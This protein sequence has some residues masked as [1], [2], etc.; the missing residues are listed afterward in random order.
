MKILLIILIYII[1]VFG[2]WLW[3]YFQFSY[4]KIHTFGDILD[5]TNGFAYIPFINTIAGV[6]LVCIFGMIYVLSYTIEHIIAWLK[7][8]QLWERI[9]N[10]KIKK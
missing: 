4:K 9:R 5:L 7:L 3:T 6:V 10:I 2:W 8:E 1:T